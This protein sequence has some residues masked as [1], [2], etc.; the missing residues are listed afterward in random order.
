MPEHQHKED[1]SDDD[2]PCPHIKSQDEDLSPGAASCK[3]DPDDA[4]D[5]LL[6]DEAK[7]RYTSADYLIVV[8]RKVQRDMFLS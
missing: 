4:I 8:E 6:R 5:F 3:T 2:R 7:R 1:T